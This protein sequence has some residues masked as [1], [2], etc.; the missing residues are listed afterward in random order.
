M[1]KFVFKKCNFRDKFR[2]RVDGSSHRD[3]RRT[4]RVPLVAE[5]VGNAQRNQKPTKGD[6]SVN[7][8]GFRR[9]E[10]FNLR[11]EIIYTAPP[12]SFRSFCVR[13]PRIVISHP[14]PRKIKTPSSFLQPY[15]HTHTH[16]YFDYILIP[17]QDIQTVASNDFYYF[18]FFYG[19]EDELL[20]FATKTIL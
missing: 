12:T 19:A 16:L 2:W 3:T 20:S 5:V 4:V 6:T 14:P 18:I 11:P 1:I 15:T 13:S 7:L 9:K 10:S 17:H 8:S